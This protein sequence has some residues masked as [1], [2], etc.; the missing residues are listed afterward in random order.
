MTVDK[1]TPQIYSDH[2][3]IDARSL[4]MHG[5][6]ARKL[7]ANPALI[8]QARSTLARWR[9]QATEPVPS[10]FLEWERILERSPEA[11]AEAQ[12]RCI[13]C[14]GPSQPRCSS[15]L[16][17]DPA[18]NQRTSIRVKLILEDKRRMCNGQEL[19]TSWGAQNIGQ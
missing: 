15:P 9:A 14:R 16:R 13:C 2:Q 18:Y 3:R 5:L 6:V 7:L 17:L 10:Y 8:N 1:Q 4:A 11:I 19:R 12:P